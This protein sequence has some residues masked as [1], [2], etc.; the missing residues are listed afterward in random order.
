[1]WAS[2]K[3]MCDILKRRA[4]KMALAQ[5]IIAPR[6]QIIPSQNAIEK[7]QPRKALDLQGSFPSPHSHS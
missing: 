5:P 1:M 3:Q 7:I 6:H 4:T 2:N